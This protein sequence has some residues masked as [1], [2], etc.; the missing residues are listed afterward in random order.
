[1]GAAVFYSPNNVSIEEIQ[2]PSYDNKRGGVILRV[3][4]CAV[5]GYDVRVFRNGHPKVTP[6]IILGHEICG[7]I[8]ETIFVSE[9]IGNTIKTSTIESGT[10]VAVCPIIPCLRC[11]YCLRSQYNLCINLKEIGSTINGGFAEYIYIPEQTLKIGGLVQVPAN[12][13]N[14]EAVLLEPLACCLNGFSNT[15]PLI[16][17]L[18]SPWIV[19]LGDGPIGL[20]HLQI[21]KNIYNANT[22]LVGKIPSRLQKAKDMGAD[23]TILLNE[24]SIN[25]DEAVSRILGFSE[26]IGANMAVIATSNPEALDFATRILRKKSKINIFAGM[27]EGTSLRVDS[28]WLHYNEISITGSFSS[29]PRMLREACRLVSDKKI[30][31]SKIIT[32]K[33]PLTNIEGAIVATEKY[34]GLRTVINNFEKV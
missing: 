26:G 20:L 24:N 25:D 30:E 17:G 2:F 32:H 14:E 18:T 7:E 33:Y 4:A 27:P 19:I 21:S 12:L 1:M 10:R 3:N 5:C 11:G 15:A 28:N 13:S 34:Y 29:T 22:I 31:L 16:Q 9:Q 23:E 8:L 6:P